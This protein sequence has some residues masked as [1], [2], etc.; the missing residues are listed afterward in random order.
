MA[1]QASSP[2]SIINILMVR[3][4]YFE[5]ACLG[6]YQDSSIVYQFQSSKLFRIKTILK[7]MLPVIFLNL[8][9]TGSFH[10]CEITS[11]NIAL[12]RNNM[13]IKNVKF[14]CRTLKMWSTYKNALF[15]KN[16]MMSYLCLTI[17]MIYLILL[18]GDVELNPGPASIDSGSISNDLSDSSIIDLSIFEQNFSIVH[19]NIQSLVGKL[20][21]IQIEL[22]H[23]DVIA[24]S[25]SWLSDNVSTDEILFQNFQRPF[26]KDRVENSYGGVIIYVKE[27]IP[28]KRRLDLEIH[29]L[30][31]IWL[32]IKL[33]NKTILLS[34]VYRPPNSPAQT[35]ADIENSIDLAYDTNIGNIVITGDFN[36]FPDSAAQILNVDLERIAHWAAMWLVNFN[37]NKNEA[38]LI[39]RKIHRIN[40][41]VLYFNH[42]PIE[43]V[44]THKHLGVYISDKCDWQAHLEYIQ[45]KAWSRVHLLRSLKFVLDRKSL[46]TM[47]F[48][49]IRPILEYADVVWDNCTQQQMNDLE[50][51]QIEAG[52]IVSGATKL[53][54]LDRLYQE[55]GWLKL[56]ERR[57]LHKLYLFY[58]MENGL[59]TDYLAELIPPH[60]RD[61][62][63]YSLRNADNLRQ[64][65]ASSRSY[66]DSFLPSTIREWN[67]LPDDIKSTPSLLSF[68]HKLEKETSKTPK[69]YYCGD[70]ISQILH[71]RLRTGCSALRYYL[72]N[73]N[74]VP[75]ALCSCGNV[76]NNF[77]FLLECQ[78]YNVMRRE[79]LQ[80]VS[81]FTDVSEMVLLF[82]DS[83]LS[84]TNNQLVF[85][86]V[87]RY[88]YQTKRF[89]S[90]N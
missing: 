9:Y 70:R 69:Y 72:Y 10:T 74:L 29:G 85:K 57:K 87:H 56:S 25:E 16:I 28:C 68:K 13:H 1:N 15:T 71:T 44:Q 90:G 14:P 52:R 21:Q 40:H 82:G 66:Y 23:F 6:G 73:R 32:E 47:Y 75:D 59:A 5:T 81:R 11:L 41:P 67:K 12:Q 26:R 61:E 86:A 42:I 22:S 45:A 54:A 46:Q 79:M 36:D 78:R 33:K 18:A 64:I 80:T 17:W 51:I 20:D 65:H 60:V 76:E 89:S 8:Y 63:S 77:H 58:K 35:L 34:L 88:I 39:S 24:L 37:P 31:C 62:T 7:F 27:N 43:E 53:V 50:K 83:N 38:M 30:E 3:I 19:Y 55:L 4:K 84:D 2:L 48:T 49:F